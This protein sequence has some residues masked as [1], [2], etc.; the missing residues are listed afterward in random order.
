MTPLKHF[1]VL[2]PRERLEKGQHYPFVPMESITPGRR[3][4]EAN[5]IRQAGGGAKFRGGDTLF[6]RITPCLEN[7][8]IAQFKASSETIAFGSTEY[9]VMRAREGVS[10]PGY[11]F[12]LASSEYVRKPA[13][14]S[15]SGA[16]GR[17]R[18]DVAAIEDLDIPVTCLNTQRRISA[19]LSAYDDLIE[20]NTRRIAI[21]EEMARRLYEEWFVHFR[22]PGHEEV[23]FKETE[24]GRIPEGW[25]VG[26]LSD[27]CKINGKSVNPGRMPDEIYAHYSFPAFDAGKHPEVETGECIM[28]NKLKFSVPALL[29]AKLNPRIPRVWNVLTPPAH[30][31]VCS[32]EFVPL[33]PKEGY[34][35]AFI[36]VVVMSEA[37]RNYLAGLAAGTSTSHQRVKPKDVMLAPLVIPT[38][39]LLKH[40]NSHLQPMAVLKDRLRQMNRNLRIQRDLLLPKLVSGA[41][42]VSD[43]PLPDEASSEA[44]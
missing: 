37:F 11:V 8:K 4:V 16:S 18:A 22:F 41:I 14:K 7:G 43:M 2:N 38:S 21:L 44:A 17:Q 27:I 39:G 33:I 13:E 24:L 35:T 5:A 3:Y 29:L 32:T 31:A 36:E 34:S 42:D 28:S 6:A 25:R 15:M 9:W 10:D 23:E 30:T 12:Y 1:I 26:S 19:I 20:N 40:L